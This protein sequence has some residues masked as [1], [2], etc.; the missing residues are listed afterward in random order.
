MMLHIINFNNHYPEVPSFFGV[1][2]NL[3]KKAT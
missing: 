3:K 1:N 2:T